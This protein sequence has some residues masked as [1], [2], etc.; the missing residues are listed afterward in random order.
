MKEGPL[1]YLSLFWTCHLVIRLIVQRMPAL[2]RTPRRRKQTRDYKRKIKRTRKAR[3][4]RGRWCY[5]LGGA[6]ALLVPASGTDLL[7]GR[8]KGVGLHVPNA[9]RH[10]TTA[11]AT[12]RWRL[13]LAG[14]KRRILPTQLATDIRRYDMWPSQQS[15]LGECSRP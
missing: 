1:A 8:E 12:V 14:T 9:W 4:S 6:S 13:M 2:W 5:V 3:G 15:G 11:M 7:I 10:L